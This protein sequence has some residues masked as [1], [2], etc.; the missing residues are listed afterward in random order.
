MPLF[1]SA[2]SAVVKNLLHFLL[3]QVTSHLDPTIALK[4]VKFKT[5]LDALFVAAA[6]VEAA[7]TEVVKVGEAVAPA[8]IATVDAAKAVAP[9]VK[10][11][12]ADAKPLVADARA[13]I[14]SVEPPT[15]PAK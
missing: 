10:Q 6:P 13:A 14:K 7:V 15:Q 5:D 4:A 11:T 12:V 9:Q 3:D 2:E 1:Q 8:V